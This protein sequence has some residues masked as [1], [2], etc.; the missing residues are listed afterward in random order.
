MVTT[1]RKKGETAQRIYKLLHRNP[2]LTT[3]E[4]C[5]HL[6]DVPPGTVQITVSRMRRKGQIE[7]RGTKTERTP[8]GKMVP[9]N[10]YH[11][12]YNSRP[13]PTV[14]PKV[15]PIPK[16]EAPKVVAPPPMA[17]VA[18]IKPEPEG[19]V[20]PVAAREV[21]MLRHLGD[22][23]KALHTLTEQ[24]DALIGVLKDTLADLAETKDELEQ[25]RQR[26]NWWDKLKGLFA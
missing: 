4:I 16:V 9:Y 11:V 10:T 17:N 26:R 2:D 22:I 12:K 15:R 5:K 1:R 3:N 23:Y 8:A 13:R 19:P 6:S 25:E 24:Q 20:T 21:V 14:K 18:P 7:A